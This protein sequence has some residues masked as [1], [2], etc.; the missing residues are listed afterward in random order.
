MSMSK[1]KKIILVVDDN[2]TI[3]MLLRYSIAPMAYEVVEAVNGKDGLS[4]VEALDRLETPPILI[5]SDVSMPDMDGLEFIETVRTFD[6]TTPVL[7]LTAHSD[8]ETRE[9]GRSIGA[10][11]WLVKPFVAGTV[12]QA[13]RDVLG[14]DE[15]PPEDRPPPKKPATEESPPS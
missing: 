8:D 7:F 9:K 2:D 13:I 14:V 15:R 12:Q 10:N 6:V 11:G 5:I 4:K 3:R 1:K